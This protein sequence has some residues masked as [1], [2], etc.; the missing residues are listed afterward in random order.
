MRPDQLSELDLSGFNQGHDARA[1]EKL[2]AHI[3]AGG[4]GGVSFAVWAPNAARVSVI[5]DWNGWR[6]DASP[7]RLV[8]S[9]GV[10]HGVV[11]GAAA[12]AV[13]KYR[14]ESRVDGY[15]AEKADPYGFLHESPPATASIV[16][17]NRIR[18]EGRRVARLAQA[19]RRARRAH[20]DLRGAPRV[21]E[22]RARRGPALAHVP[23]ARARAPRVRGSPGLHA[24]RADARHGAPVLRLMGLRGHRILR[25]V[26]PLR[27]RRGPDV[28][29]R[30]AARGRGR[31]HPRLGAGALPHRRARPRVLRR[32]APLRARRSASGLPPGVAQRHLQLRAKRGAELSPVERHVLARSLPRRRAPRRR[33]VVDALPRLRA[34]AGR[35]DPERPRRAARTSRPSTSC[36]S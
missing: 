10:W 36:A 7:L 21:V 35:V 11:P 9:T 27:D 12:G 19:A 2:G 17:K 34:Q 5:G 16:V 28:P 23:R 4:A 22:A 3:V 18:L 8:G 6:P 30:R 25:A 26:A 13:Y 20:L 15:V 14:I 24:R 1:Y 31:R 32:H 33:R 29:H